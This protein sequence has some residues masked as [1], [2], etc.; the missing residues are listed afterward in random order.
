MRGL[1]KALIPI[2]LALFPWSAQAASAGFAA[3]AS[4]AEVHFVTPDGFT[5][6]DVAPQAPLPHELA[7]RHSSGQ[8]QIRLALRPLSRIE[9][10]Y[11]DPHG[12]MP[13]PEHIYPLMFESLT[14][15]LALGGDSNRNVYAQE[16]AR[17]QFGADWAAAAIF[18][19][20]APEAAGFRQGILLALH[21]SKTADAYLLLLFDDAET[22]RPLIRE[23]IGAL[24]FTP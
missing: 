19:L 14:N 18:D 21:R 2:L 13:D 23:A 24:R 9:I 6:V 4:E 11:D 5:E 3:L 16:H 20:D 22:A 8:L 15:T 10:R 17:T 7:L 1:R 12:A